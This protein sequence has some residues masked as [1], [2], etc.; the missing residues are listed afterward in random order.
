MRTSFT[1][2]S[3]F[4][5]LPLWGN[6]AIVLT[7]QVK[8]L[9]GGKW[10]PVVTDLGRRISDNRNGCILIPTSGDLSQ[11]FFKQLLKIL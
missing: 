2:N 5:G 9:G 4:P 1:G 6:Q 11:V 7:D 10:C 8:D 3:A